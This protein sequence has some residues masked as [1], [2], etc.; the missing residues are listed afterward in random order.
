M[1]LES[2]LLIL[3]D[4]FIASKIL[5]TLDMTYFGANELRFLTPTKLCL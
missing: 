4:V 1:M 2:V 5:R 3:I